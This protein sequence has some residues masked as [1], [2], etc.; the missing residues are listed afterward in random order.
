MG[1]S[2]VKAPILEDLITARENTYFGKGNI[3][4]SAALGDLDRSNDLNKTGLWIVKMLDKTEKN[5]CKKAIEIWEIHQ[6]M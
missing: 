4:I 6:K 5:H 1:G 2:I 3:T